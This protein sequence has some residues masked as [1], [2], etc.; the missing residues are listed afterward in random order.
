MD[1]ER[2]RGRRVR[3]VPQTFRSLADGWPL[4]ANPTR[5]EM[6]ASERH[7]LHRRNANQFREALGETR[8]GHTQLS[9]R[10]CDGPSRLGVP[11]HER[12]SA[13]VLGVARCAEPTTAVLCS[14]S[15]PTNFEMYWARTSTNRDTA[16]RANTER[17]DYSPPP[18]HDSRTFADCCAFWFP[19]AHRAAKPVSPA[20]MRLEPVSTTEIT[21]A[22]LK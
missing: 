9:R 22:P 12:M 4:I 18:A 20:A 14:A 16:L 3:P 10:R 11:V 1:V 19:V 17:S 5:C 6:H 2:A 13:A 15:A 21:S 7:V 8:A